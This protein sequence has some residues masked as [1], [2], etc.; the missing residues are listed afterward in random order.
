MDQL[1]KLIVWRRL[2]GGHHVGGS[3]ITKKFT[4]RILGPAAIAP[5]IVIAGCSSN[6]GTQPPAPQASANTSAPVAAVFPPASLAAFRAFAAT[7]DAAQVTKV[8]FTN[9]GLASCPDPTYSVTVPRSLGVR[10]VEADLSAFFVQAGLLGNQCGPVVFAFHSKAQA[11]AGN[12][13]TAGRVIITT[14]SPG[15]PWNLEVDAGSAVS[16]AGSFNFDF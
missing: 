2:Q 10:A 3:M 4:L 8:G 15:P 11:D 14:N 5:A 12:G 16:E 6:T 13:Y 1:D 9:E 7:G